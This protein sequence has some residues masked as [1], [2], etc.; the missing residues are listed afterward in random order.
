MF[1]LNGILL[2]GF[3]K[4]LASFKVVLGFFST[5][6]KWLFFL[7]S[8]KNGVGRLGLEIGRFQVLGQVSGAWESPKSFLEEF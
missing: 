3:S 7:Q 4:W 6:K 1:R 5:R 2:N 8:C